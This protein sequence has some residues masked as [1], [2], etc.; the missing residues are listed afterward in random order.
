[1]TKHPVS[2]RSLV[3]GNTARLFPMY[4][5]GADGIDEDA[6]CEVNVQWILTEHAAVC[7]AEEEARLRNM[8]TQVVKSYIQRLRPS[9]HEILERCLSGQMPLPTFEEA[10]EEVYR[11]GDGKA[12]RM[13]DMIMK[14][15]WEAGHQYLRLS[16]ENLTKGQ[17]LLATHTE[18]KRRGFRDED[19]VRLLYQS[20]VN[21]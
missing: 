7:A 17:R 8:V 1:M 12:V 14:G 5:R 13:I 6:L 3:R 16:D 18:M 10:C 15:L 19:P 20:A 11:D 9:A 4:D 21:A 2:V